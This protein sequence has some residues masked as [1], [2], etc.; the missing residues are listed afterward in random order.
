MRLQPADV[1]LSLCQVGCL[2][3]R[4]DGPFRFSPQWHDDAMRLCSHI[5]FY[6]AVSSRKETID[7]FIVDWVVWCAVPERR[8]KIIPPMRIADS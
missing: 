1:C 5:H 3:K 6:S 2:V 4:F 8:H 7:F